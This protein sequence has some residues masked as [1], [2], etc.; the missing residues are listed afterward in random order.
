MGMVRADGID[1]GGDDIGN[2][3]AL[4]TTISEVNNEVANILGA[5]FAIFLVFLLAI[6]KKEGAHRPVTESAAMS[7]I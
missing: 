4:I 5:P 1:L 6:V 2:R 7:M 3:W